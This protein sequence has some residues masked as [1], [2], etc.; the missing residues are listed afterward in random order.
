MFTLSLDLLGYQVL[1]G[2]V[3]DGLIHPFPGLVEVFNIGRPNGLEEGKDGLPV[4]DTL[5][6]RNDGN[7]S[8][9]SLIS[10]EN[11]WVRPTLVYGS[12]LVSKV[13]RVCQTRIE[14]QAT[15][16]RE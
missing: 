1:L 9:I 12:D 3:V 5:R 15:G 10:V 8:S 16:W 6:C 11:A 13:V 7:G 4:L 14:T 2:R